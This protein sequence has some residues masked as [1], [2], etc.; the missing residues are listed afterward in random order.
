MSYGTSITEAFRLVGSYSGRIL[1]S[2][3]PANLPIQQ[4]TNVELVGAVRI[5]MPASAISLP[6]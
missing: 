4:S 3:T 6:D 1:K 5:I 2:E